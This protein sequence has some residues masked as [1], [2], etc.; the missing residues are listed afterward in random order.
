MYEPSRNDGSH[1]R[2]DSSP[3]PELRVYSKIP[4]P[5]LSY[6]YYMYDIEDGVNH[7]RDR[8]DHG[9]DIDDGCNNGSGNSNGNGGYR[10]QGKCGDNDH[11]K[12]D[13]FSDHRSSP[14]S[15][16]SNHRHHHH[17]HN[18]EHHHHHHHSIDLRLIENLIRWYNQ[19]Q[20]R[21]RINTPNDPDHLIHSPTDEHLR[22][23]SPMQLSVTTS[24]RIDDHPPLQNEIPSTPQETPNAQKDQTH[25]NNALTYP[26]SQSFSLSNH[27]HHHTHHRHH[28]HHSRHSRRH[29]S[30]HFRRS[31]ST[32]Y[33][34]MADEVDAWF[35]GGR[36]RISS[37]SSMS[38]NRGGSDRGNGE[39]GSE[40]R[41]V[42][43]IR[44]TISE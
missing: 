20:T 24:V 17:T 43:F 32:S 3:I 25:D 23:R 22:R 21:D 40:S 7:A 42:L 15:H 35:G 6:E 33:S 18:H 41:R 26:G 38:S 30:D 39:W 44:R 31:R 13:T 28:H 2:L 14:P 9:P 16:I 19:P 37:T 29:G 1:T 11:K 12:S 8:D 27:R 10:D 4:N 36:S 34:A 5:L